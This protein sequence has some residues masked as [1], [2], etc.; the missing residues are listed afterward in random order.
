MEIFAKRFLNVKCK[1]MF[2]TVVCS[3]NYSLHFWGMLCTI[4]TIR[5]N[6]HKM[7]SRIKHQWSKIKQEVQVQWVPAFKSQKVV[8]QSNQKTIASLSAF[9]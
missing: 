5:Q 9:R 2:V 7:V 8:H 4:Y 3:W 1:E 6:V